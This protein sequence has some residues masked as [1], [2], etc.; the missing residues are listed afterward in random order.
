MEVAMPKHLTVG[1]TALVAC[2]LCTTPVSIRFS[3]EAGLL[4]SVNSVSAEIGHPL[5]ATSVAGVHRRQAR[6]A[7]RRGYYES[8]QYSNYG[9]GRPLL[10]TAHA[11]GSNRPWFASSDDQQPYGSYQHTARASAIRECATSADKYPEYVWGNFEMFVYR[12]C[13]TN[14]GQLE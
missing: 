1:A 4:L 13:M 3:P 11:Y 14:H 2:V 7:D 6:R 10:E 12:A 8:Q 9:Y 5:T